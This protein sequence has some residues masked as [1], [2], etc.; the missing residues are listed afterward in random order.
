MPTVAELVTG[1]RLPATTAA[2]F[3]VGNAAQ[4]GATAAGTD[5]GTALA[6][7][8]GVDRV[9]VTT[10]AASTGVRL[11]ATRFKGDTITVTNRG[12][13][14]ITV[15]PATGDTIDGGSANAGAPLA[16]GGSR[17]FRCV[18]DASTVWA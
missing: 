6:I 10:A 2:S 7:T 12:A 13:N 15:Y 9:V 4:Y 11:P 14:A 1:A 18:L 16:V 5:Q 17:T 8:T 3:V